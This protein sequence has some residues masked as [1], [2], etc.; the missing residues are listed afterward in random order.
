[1]RRAHHVAIATALLLAAGTARPAEVPLPAVLQVLGNVTAAA[2]PVANVLVIALNLQSFDAL[3]THSALDGSFSLPPLPTGVYKII[4]LKP[5]FLPTTTTVVPTKA[6]HSLKLRL[7]TE[8]QA[9]GRS[10]N[11]E[12]WEIRGSLPPNIL[13]EIDDVLA[14]PVAVNAAL[15]VPRLR[16][17]MFSMTGVSDTSVSPAVAQTALGVHSRIGDNWQLGIRGNLHRVDDPNDG[18]GFGTPL[19]ESSVMSMELRSSPTDAYR[20]ASTKSWWRYNNEGGT[21]D[22]PERQAGLRSHNFEWEHGDARLQVRYLAQQNLF[23]SNPLGSDL[24]EIAGDTPLF[25]T[26]RNAMGVSLRVTQE[27][28]HD[29]A[30]S[31]VRMADL[32][33][34]ASFSVA[35]SF[36]VHYGMSSRLGVAGSE[37]APRTGA[38]WKLTKSTS[39]IASGMYKVLDQSRT[40]EALPMIVVA[41]EEGR[42]LPRYAYSFGFVS[43]GESTDRFSAIATVSVVDT[44]LRMVFTSG[45]EPFWDG[46]YVDAGDTR[47][48]LRVSYRKE[49]G[50]F[51]FDVATSAGT[52]THPQKLTESAGAEKVYVTADLQSTYSLT[53]TTLAASY[54][55]L[56]QP[57]PGGNPKY[58]SDRMNL[59]VAQSLHLPLDLKLLLGF[60][61]GKAEHSPLLIETIDPEGFSRRYLGGLAVNF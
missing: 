42:A 44:P 39:L 18:A 41:S 16:G 17:E 23:A 46:L 58:R 7:E 19:A 10:V 49:I 57:Q 3:Q 29:T 22:A 55:Q 52:A 60:E 48:D 51:A 21:P 45:S 1:M 38:E 59:H 26:R 30:T 8:K 61:V 36:I 11:Q 27:S 20:V 32:A 31:P 33:A 40:S 50:R 4:A 56:Q 9:K 43:N 53:G 13:H 25:Q 6:D 24:I 5:G 28:L 47:R 54:R 14:Q 2:R 15:D 12:M 34:N 37:W 35:P